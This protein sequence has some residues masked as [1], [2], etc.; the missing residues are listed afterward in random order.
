MAKLSQSTLSSGA[1]GSVGASGNTLTG[2]LIKPGW[3][4]NRRIR[5]SRCRMR[6]RDEGASEMLQIGVGSGNES[7]GSW[8]TAVLASQTDNPRVRRVLRFMVRSWLEE[9]ENHA[10]PFQQRPDTEHLIGKQD[11]NRQR[12]S[13]QLVV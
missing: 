12:K 7:T 2:S 4:R 13:P 5:W 11:R 9:R 1:T 6:S 10:G 8:D 3:K